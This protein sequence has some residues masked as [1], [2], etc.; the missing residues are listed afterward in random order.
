MKKSMIAAVFAAA[1]PM[2][3]MAQDMDMQGTNTTPQ[4]PTEICLPISV[5]Q[6]FCLA[7]DSEAQILGIDQNIG[8]IV[9]LEGR[10]EDNGVVNENC[11]AIAAPAIQQILQIGCPE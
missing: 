6:Q 9:Q 1:L 3:A 7:A 4:E 11:V 2:S 10:F 8:P 5:S